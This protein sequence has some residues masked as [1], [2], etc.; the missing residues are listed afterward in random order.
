[1]G[2]IEA[3]ATVLTLGSSDGKSGFGRG[4]D[5]LRYL[6]WNFFIFYFNLIIYAIS[7][8]KKHFH[9]KFHDITGCFH[10]FQCYCSMIVHIDQVFISF[11]DM[12]S[13]KA[14]K[15]ACII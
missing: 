9:V 14:G 4:G 10:S 5:I 6:D 3:A 2:G 7:I 13:F 12:S 8:T 1:M 15:I 11:R